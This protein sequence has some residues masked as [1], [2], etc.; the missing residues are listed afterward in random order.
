MMMGRVINKEEYG[1]G[2]TAMKLILGL[3]QSL[4][5]RDPKLAV[6]VPGAHGSHAA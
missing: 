4:A 2:L 6:T 5:E 3:T 1:N